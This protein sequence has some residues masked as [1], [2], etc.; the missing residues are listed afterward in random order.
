MSTVS[1]LFRNSHYDNGEVDTDLVGVFDSKE[2]LDIV[3]KNMRNSKSGYG[4]I[5]FTF[6]TQEYSINKKYIS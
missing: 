4:A 2:S 1:V 3:V 5:R 6:H